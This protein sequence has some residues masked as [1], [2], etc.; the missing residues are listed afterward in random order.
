MSVGL[1]VGGRKVGS[2]EVDVTERIWQVRARV[3]VEVGRIEAVVAV[4]ESGE[5]VIAVMGE[6]IV[7]FSGISL[8][9]MYGG[10][11]GRGT[12]EVEKESFSAEA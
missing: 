7:S 6:E 5:A 2:V 9:K 4:A 12:G 11:G 1:R 10:T 3:M 8:L